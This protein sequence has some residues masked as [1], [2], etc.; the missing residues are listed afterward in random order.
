LGMGQC[1]VC[2]GRPACEYGAKTAGQDGGMGGRRILENTCQPGRLPTASIS[3]GVFRGFRNR[4]DLGHAKA[5]E[6]AVIVFKT[7]D[8]SETHFS[9]QVPRRC[10]GPLAHEPHQRWGWVWRPS[11]PSISGNPEGH[12]QS[13]KGGRLGRQ[14][15]L[16]SRTRP[17][18]G[19]EDPPSCPL[20]RSR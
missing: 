18:R 9:E 7:R 10:P 4:V 20:P 15:A 2:K 19:Q 8:H 5:L 14:E 1:T 13:K 12:L 6:T 16:F 17:R 11:L 3:R